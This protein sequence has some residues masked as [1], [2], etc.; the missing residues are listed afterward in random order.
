MPLPTN[1][2]GDVA[3][4][5]SAPLGAMMGAVGRG[6]AEAQGAM[7]A[8]TLAR[9]KAMFRADD[10]VQNEMRRLGYTPTWYRIPEVEAEIT[11]SLSISGDSRSASAPPATGEDA[12]IGGPHRIKLYAAPIDA[13]YTNKY[14]FN[15]SAASRVKMKIVAVPPSPEVASAKVV[16]GLGNKTYEEA[17]A[18]LD[19]L[20][21][22]YRLKDPRLVPAP[23]AKVRSFS[24]RVGT[25]LI[26]GQAVILNV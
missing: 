6:V 1:S 2:A 11:V 7:D 20:Q 4:T 26:A 10:E 16:P 3:E 9:F 13:S 18:L 8:G 24:P 19:E 14:D 25:V 12:A 5:L 23:D 22:P 21:I 17:Q 15:F